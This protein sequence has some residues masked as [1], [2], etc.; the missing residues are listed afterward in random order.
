MNMK[1][2]D[3]ELIISIIQNFYGPEQKQA[4][5]QNI[6]ILDYDIP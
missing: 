2:R 4:K 6:S 1:K 5:L 3:K